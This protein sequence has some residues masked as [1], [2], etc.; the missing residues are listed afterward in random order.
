MKSQLGNRSS[1]PTISSIPTMYIVP[2]GALLLIGWSVFVG[3]AEAFKR[4]LRRGKDE[5]E[6]A[7]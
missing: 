5:S 3:S 6:V 7:S 4:L 2:P 1:I